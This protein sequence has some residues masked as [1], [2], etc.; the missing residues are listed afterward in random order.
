MAVYRPYVRKDKLMP[1]ILANDYT[2]LIEGCGHQVI[3]GYTYCRKTEGAVADEDLVFVGPIT[4][5]NRTSCVEFKVYGPDGSIVFGSSIPKK[6]TRKAIPWNALLKRD[7]FEIQDRG[8]WIYTYNVFWLDSDGNENMSVS[9]GEI[10]LR[11]LKDNYTSLADVES[12]SNFAWQWKD[13]SGAIIKITTG[14]RTYVS[15]IK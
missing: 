2:A 5:C 6:Q 4:N 13:K 11:I 3:S 8:F 14:M 12:D 7:T 9:E 1:A 15:K 10:R